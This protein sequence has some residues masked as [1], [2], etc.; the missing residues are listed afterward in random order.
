MLARDLR[1]QVDSITSS[2][3]ALALQSSGYLAEEYR[4]G[5]ESIEK[6]RSKPRKSLGMTY[7]RLM[8]GSCCPGVHTDPAGKSSPIRDLLQ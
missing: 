7:P 6:G 3:I 2:V 1:N 8:Q 5:I 4:A